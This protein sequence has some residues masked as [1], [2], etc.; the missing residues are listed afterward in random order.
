VPNQSALAMADVG[1]GFS[2]ALPV[3]VKPRPVREL[4]DIQSPHFM[5][6]L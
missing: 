5:R 2:E 4:V 3:P 6:R 1:E